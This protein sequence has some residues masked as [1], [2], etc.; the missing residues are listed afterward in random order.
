[1]NANPLFLK[2][3]AVDFRAVEFFAGVGGFATA[4]PE[5]EVAAA[6]DIHQGAAEVYAANNSH[7]FW[8][9]EIE[10]I[11]SEDILALQANLWWMSP[12]C[13]PYTLRGL[14]RDVVDPRAQSL[15][16]LIDLMADCKPEYL[17][18][19]NVHGFA[20]SRALGRL[21]QQLERC[22]YSWQTIELCPTEMGWPNKRPRFYLMASRIAKLVPWRSVPE[23]F[24]R[25]DDMVE[26]H[27]DLQEIPLELLMDESIIA[28]IEDGIDRCDPNSERATACFGSSYG[29]S[30]LNSGSYLQLKDGRYRRFLP[31]EVANLLGFPPSFN[32]PVACRTRTLWKLLGNSLSIPAVRYVLSHLP[33]GPSP[34]LPWR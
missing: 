8:T 22:G 31:R 14:R 9:R 23:Y 28:T 3:N 29:R 20:K 12:P 13:Q 7:P 33:G 26:R 18:L 5:V 2:S 24:Y 21:C 11:A 15:L 17:L 1:M 19:E 10:S 6:I 30:L 32:L 16:R 25:T 27:V 4:W 34:K